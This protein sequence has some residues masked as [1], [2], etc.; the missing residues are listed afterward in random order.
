MCQICHTV[1]K[2]EEGMFNHLMKKHAET[3]RGHLRIIDG[4]TCEE[5]SELWKQLTALNANQ[6]SSENP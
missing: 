5:G 1:R 4:F 3:M 2:T 6:K